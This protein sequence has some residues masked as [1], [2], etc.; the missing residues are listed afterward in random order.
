VLVYSIGI[1]T[2]VVGTSMEPALHNGQEVLI[3]KLIYQFSSPKRGDVIV[4]RPNGNQNSHFYVKRIVGLPGE[5]IQIKQG[6]V[7]INGEV[8]TDDAADDT[9]EAGIAETEIL[10]GDDEYFVLGDN[11]DNSEDSRSANIGNVG[12]D[13]IEG[14]AWYHL[15]SGEEKMGRIY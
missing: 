10:L 15:K 7:Y 9:K 4:F 11:R 2:S 12:R 1:R 6:Q 14:K 13:M 3:D 5:T 8:Y